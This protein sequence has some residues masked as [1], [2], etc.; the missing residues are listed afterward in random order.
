MRLAEEDLLLRHT[1]FGYA[2]GFHSIEKFSRARKNALDQQVGP[3]LFRSVSSYTPYRRFCRECA[4]SEFFKLGESYWHLS[5]NLPGVQFCTR[6]RSMLVESAL[7]TAGFGRN[8]SLPHEA[9]VQPGRQL[10]YSDLLAAISFESLKVCKGLSRGLHQYCPK[11][12]YRDELGKLG[13]ILPNQQVG[14]VKLISWARSLAGEQLEIL[15]LA[16]EGLETWL[17]DLVCRYKGST[18]K[19]VVIRALLRVSSKALDSSVDLSRVNVR[20]RDED[21]ATA[22]AL[23]R[24]EC[25]RLGTKLR[26]LETLRTIGAKGAYQTGGYPLLVAEVIKLYDSPARAM[27]RRGKPSF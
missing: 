10:P 24:A 23:K 17:P 12:F 26:L 13:L 2:T 1:V 5:H 9:C 6:H 22:F 16:E 4:R 25:E 11:S 19:H 3:A 7:S 14:R 21:L 27:E 20:K 8:R 18:L 15:G